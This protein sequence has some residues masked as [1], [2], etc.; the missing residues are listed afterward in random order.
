M[1]Q[2]IEQLRGHATG[3]VLLL[4]LFAQNR[5]KTS[6]YHDEHHLQSVTIVSRLLLFLSFHRLHPTSQIEF[7]IWTTKLT[8]EVSPLS[9]CTGDCHRAQSRLC[10]LF[11]WTAFTSP[12]ATTKGATAA[13]NQPI[14]FQH[15]TSVI[16]VKW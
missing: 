10:P 4:L 11:E 8:D 7:S 9:G 12:C 5:I 2:S 1:V 15:E 16:I 14:F 6:E 13:T 3:G